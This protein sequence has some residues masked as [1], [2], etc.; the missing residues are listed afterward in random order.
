ELQ[1]FLRW[2][3]GKRLSEQACRIERSGKIVERGRVRRPLDDRPTHRKIEQTRFTASVR[4][5]Y[6]E[7]QRRFFTAGA[8]LSRHILKCDPFPMGR[9]GEGGFRS[10][11]GQVR[12]R[13]SGSARDRNLPNRG[14]TGTK[15]DEVNIGR[16]RRKC[17][18]VCSFSRLCAGRKLSLIPS[19]GIHYPDL[20]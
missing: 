1:D 18:R 9:H 13:D 12:N 5:Q 7:G 3:T 15:L 11:V 19:I 2:P 6:S 4:W 16:I 8:W 20:P 10:G 17:R 14:W